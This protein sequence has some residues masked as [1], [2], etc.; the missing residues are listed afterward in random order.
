MNLQ[1]IPPEAPQRGNQ[2]VKRAWGFWATVGFGLA[3]MAAFL[4]VQT[5]VGA[6]VAGIYLAG[7]PSLSFETL[8]ARILEIEG[9]ITS[10]ATLATGVLCTGLIIAFV[11]VKKG[12]SVTEYL[13]LKRISLKTGLVLVAVTLGII[14]TGDVTSYLLG[15]PIN[16]ESMMHVYDTS[17]VP[18]LLWIA[19]I[20]FA[21]V[22]E[23]TFF[24]GF[25]FEGFRQSRLRVLGTILLASLLW[26]LLH[27][28]YDAYDI[29]W[30]FGTGIVLGYVR[31]KTGSLWSP[32]LMHAFMNLVATIEVVIN[33]NA[34]VG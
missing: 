3:V 11:K 1:G 18:A 28:Q 31:H 34:L 22:F 6:L 4:I 10:L 15:R 26:S 23:E 25:L 21:P 8:S 12:A 17:V 19:V 2:P 33:I 5:L 16:P 24:R 7:S 13:G 20:V 29:S 9:L 32:L 27:V 30:I 14:V